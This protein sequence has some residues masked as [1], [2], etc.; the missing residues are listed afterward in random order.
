MRP[1]QSKLYQIID[2]NL[3]RCGEGLRVIEEIARFVFSDS[4]LQRKTKHL[5]QQLSR[6]F[7]G[8]KSSGLDRLRL[9]GCGRDSESD[10]GRSYSTS[11]EMKRES[12]ESVLRSNFSRVE[13]SARVLEEFSKT[14]SPKLG[15]KIKEFRFK[16][17]TLEKD[18]V[19]KHFAAGKREY[20]RNIG[21]YPIVDR[22]Q[23]GKRSVL[24][25]ARQIIDGGAKILQYRDKV[26]DDGTIFDTCKVLMSLCRKKGVR[27][28]VNDAVDIAV[29]ID[30]DGVHL[31]QT[32]IPVPEARKL[33]GPDKII[34]KSSHNIPEAGRTAKE[35]IDYLAVGPIFPTTTKPNY[36]VA[37]LK[38][39]EWAKANISL[40]II[41]IG[42]INLK[43]IG[44]V[45]KLK[46]DG[47]AVVSAILSA[48]DLRDQTIRFA[49]KC[50]AAWR[51][52]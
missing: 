24:S 11:A 39:L 36:R 8:D 40:P 38:L 20:L 12:F 49:R 22:Q 7:V 35:D 15:E 2:V 27:F 45:V 5:R 28:I 26:S 29:A 19:G 21:I 1:A 33:L 47:I 31:G 10:I 3:N 30:A 50:R 4:E 52:K 43:N 17:Y 48:P 51:K 42:G 32:D 9:I 34:G 25:V 44:P 14:I 23:I 18:F 37:G 6:F 41:A 46:P 16:L 13:E